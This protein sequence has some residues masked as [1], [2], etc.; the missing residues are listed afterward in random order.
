M[1]I[2]PAIIYLGYHCNPLYTRSKLKDSIPASGVEMSDW[3]LL[4]FITTETD[5]AK[6]VVFHTKPKGSLKSLELLEVVHLQNLVSS[7]IMC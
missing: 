6:N 1:Q 3:M 4:A 2:S 5:L 7:S